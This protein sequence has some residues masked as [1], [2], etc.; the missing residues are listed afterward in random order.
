MNI[1]LPEEVL[2]Q[3]LIKCFSYNTIFAIFHWCEEMILKVYPTASDS[4]IQE[5]A[6]IL[7]WRYLRPFITDD[8]F[9]L[10]RLTELKHKVEEPE[11][12]DFDKLEAYLNHVVESLV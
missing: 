6:D 2:N 11:P 7:I 8:D 1:D 4:F 3:N 5:E 9:Y 10:K 12:P